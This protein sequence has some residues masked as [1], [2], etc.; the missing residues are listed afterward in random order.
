MW[1][2]RPTRAH[3]RIAAVQVVASPRAVRLPIGAAVS[4]TL[5]GVALVAGGLFLA[6]LAFATPIV[7]ALTPS[8]LRPTLPQMALGGAVWAV[9]LVAPPC[10]AIVGAWRLSRVVRA[11]TVK[12]ARPILAAAATDLGDEYAAASDV[13][14]PDGRSIR[15]VVVGPFGLAVINELPPARYLRR[16]GAAWEARAPS[17]RWFHVENPLEKTAR[18]GER[19]RRWFASVERDYILKVYTAVVSDDASL[20]RTPACAVVTRDQVS[21]W[22]ASLPPARSITPDRYEEIV[23]QLTELL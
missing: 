9:A 20:S 13:R 2:F 16:T 5:A 1:S 8:A 17:G 19:V 7:G 10:F 6:W 23:D 4:G 22:L 3:A 18:D 12:P 14:L 21:A 11:L 15:N